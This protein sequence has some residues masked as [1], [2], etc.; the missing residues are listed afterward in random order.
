MKTATLNIGLARSSNGILI[1]D[2]I[3][4]ECVENF[5]ALVSLPRFDQSAT[6]RTLICQIDLEYAGNNFE[7]NLFDMCEELDQDCIAVKFDDGTGKLIGP[8]ADSWGEF[9][10]DYFIN[11]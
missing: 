2:D 5:F 3:A 10:P 8:R 4:L 7:L 11:L 1:E 6:E 9:N